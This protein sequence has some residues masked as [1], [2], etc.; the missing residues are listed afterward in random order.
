MSIW[1]TI[2]VTSIENNAIFCNISHIENV[3]NMKTSTISTMSKTTGSTASFK[4]PDDTNHVVDM[5]Q[6]QIMNR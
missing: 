6:R 4:G 1:H 5:D 2:N 3:C